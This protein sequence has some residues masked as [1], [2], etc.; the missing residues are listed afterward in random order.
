V[1]GPGSERR[2]A[3]TAA[4]GDPRDGAG[5]TSPL[6][7]LVTTL[8]WEGY[9]LYPYTPGA[10]KNATPTPF[11]IVYPP[12][13]AAGSP[14]TFDRI[15]MQGIVAGGT[16]AT[17]AVEVQFLQASGER[18]EAVA[19][20]VELPATPLS[21]LEGDGIRAEF[22]FDGITGRVRMAAQRFDDLLV[23]I[24]A[25]VDNTTEVAEGLD[26]A[27]ALR[28]SLLS[29]HVVAR[30]TG[31]RFMSPIDPPDEAAAAVMACAAVNTYPVLAS[32][33]DDALLGAAI[34]LPDH[35]QLAPESRGDLFD[36]TE[37]EEALL[38]HVLALS[39]G[40]R[41]QIAEHD[42]AVRAMVER[43]VSS[44]PQDIVALHGRVTVQDPAPP[45]DGQAGE[46]EATVDGITYRPGARVRLLAHNGTAQDHLLDGRTATVERI[47]IDYDDAVHLGVTL[48]DDPGRELMRDIG[49]YLYFKPAD[50]EVIAP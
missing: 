38:L 14:T 46:P 4:T 41:E 5:A 37:I 36:A 48:D 49:R 19:R 6:E 25:C 27:Q 1:S 40:E 12:V 30:T 17:L 32:D 33:T 18:H 15:R 34:V 9:A 47:Y 31:G 2:V 29:T 11:G 43:A 24:T 22:A 8:L 35:P 26:R 50:V 42:P 21:A 39:D 20:R 13:Y 10:T 23:R 28:S 16:E 45:R 7:E 3:R 44:T